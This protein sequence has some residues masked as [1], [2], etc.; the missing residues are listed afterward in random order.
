MPLR[1]GF[2]GRVVQRT[3]RVDSEFVLIFHS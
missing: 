2:R 3:H 1:R